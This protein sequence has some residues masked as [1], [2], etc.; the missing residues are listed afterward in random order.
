MSD[1]ESDL[2]V[3]VPWSSLSG[4]AGGDPQTA[5]NIGQGAQVDPALK[6][7]LDRLRDTQSRLAVT[8][9]AAQVPATPTVQTVKT[10][11]KTG[12][13]TWKG[14]MPAEAAE[15]I[16][17]NS[18]NYQQT[19]GHMA[20]SMSQMEQQLAAREQQARNQ[21]A[22]VQLATALSANLASQKDMPGW[23]R[24]LGQT[25]AQLNPSADQLRNERMG[26]LGQEAQLAEAGAR[27]EE[28]GLAHRQMQGD[29]QA[30]LEQK[31]RA[32]K[33][34]LAD[35]IVQTVRL[36]A[37]PGVPPTREEVTALAKVMDRDKI[38]GPEDMDNLV[39]MSGGMAR[40]AAEGKEAEL[41]RKKSLEEY[42]SGLAENRAK[43]IANVNHENRI[44]E[45]KLRFQESISPD[46]LAF[47]KERLSALNGLKIENKRLESMGV[48]DRAGLSQ[49]GEAAANDLYIGKV[50]RMLS[51]ASVDETSGPLF[52]RD[53]KT[54]EWTVNTNVLLPGTMQP[55]EFTEYK[56][57]LK[58]ELP[59]MLKLIMGGGGQGGI[60]IMRTK[61]GAKMLE[62]LG[63]SKNQRFDQI[64]GI[65]GVISD[66]NND[67]KMKIVLQHKDVPWV[68][69]YGELLGLNDPVNKNY[70][71]N[72]IDSF[73]NQSRPLPSSLTG[74]ATISGPKAGAKDSGGP[75]QKVTKNDALDEALRK[76]G[77]IP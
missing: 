20:A 24:G 9:A 6:S 36:N 38:L 21:P 3:G 69:D 61:E 60:S 73:G 57:Q 52:G 16:F 77:V 47:E 27:I 55:A 67:N 8:Q 13:R 33:D 22:W 43:D 7:Q 50:N 26:V 45:I 49:L 15:S 39:T 29:K 14:E 11:P 51:T 65:M 1:G 48:V 28:T 53:P 63:A 32:E 75:R 42:R 2:N 31:T 19:L 40:Q 54:G 44:K 46:K 4:L 58:H 12:Q 59:R 71:E 68:E 35:R 72:H 30:A 10:D 34:H 56:S 17:R 64:K 66:T 41:G 37:K 70:F 18:Q 25:A 5:Q 74:G 76:A 62:E 23:V